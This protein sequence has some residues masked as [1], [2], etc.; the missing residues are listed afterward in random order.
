MQPFSVTHG[1]EVVHGLPVHWPILHISDSHT[2]QAR[3]IAARRSPGSSISNSGPERT[4]HLN[5]LSRRTTLRASSAALLISHF[6]FCERCHFSGR[7]GRST[8]NSSF[9]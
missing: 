6:V 3:S 7:L 9:S 1:L 8:P 4:R 5:S 2:F